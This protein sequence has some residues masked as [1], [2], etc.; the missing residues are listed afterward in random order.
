MTVTLIVL[1]ALAVLTLAGL[2]RAAVA[3]ADRRR[4]LLAAGEALCLLLVA[5]ALMP[6]TP[7]VVVAWIGTVAVFAGLLGLAASRWSQLPLLAPS[8]GRRG[9]V[10]AVVH[11]V[12]L[13]A[14]IGM[15][16]AGFV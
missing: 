12:V 4:V 16:A 6:V 5:R 8:T 11:V 14:V 7:P 13:V 3:A 10:G 9:V 2:A 15:V 1:G